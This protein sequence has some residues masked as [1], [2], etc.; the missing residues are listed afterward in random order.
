MPELLEHGGTVPLWAGWAV[1]LPAA[2]HER[3]AD[4]S[5]SA[6]GADWTVDVTII[7]V[8]SAPDGQ[9]AAPDAL[10]G[11]KRVANFSG[12]GWVGCWELRQEVDGGRDVLRFATTLAATN[13]VMSCWVSVITQE[14]LNFARRLVAGI[15]HRAA[16]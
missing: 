4:G 14:Q 7:E 11:P 10:L 6:W 16:R 15:T 3:N 2:Y 12:D 1:T 8:G 5:W 9:P 13:T